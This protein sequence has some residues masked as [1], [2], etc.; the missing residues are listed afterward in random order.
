MAVFVTGSDWLVGFHLGVVVGRSLV[1]KLLI[2]PLGWAFCSPAFGT[3]GN[4]GL[5]AITVVLTPVRTDVLFRAPVALLRTTVTRAPPFTT[6]RLRLEWPTATARPGPGSRKF[7]TPARA[8]PPSLTVHP[9]LPL[10]AIRPTLQSTF[11]APW[12]LTWTVRKLRN[13]LAA[14]IWTMLGSSDEATGVPGTLP[15]SLHVVVRKSP[16]R[17]GPLP[18]QLTRLKVLVRRVPVLWPLGLVRISPP[19]TLAVRRHPFVVT[20]LPFPLRTSCE[21]FTTLMQSG[22]ELLGDSGTRPAGPLL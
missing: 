22:V 16:C 8:L 4:W 17:F 20:S 19:R 18:R 11:S 15:C 7:L 13:R 5:N 10:G 1:E 3:T 21:L 9:L 2:R 6:I 14:T 12:L